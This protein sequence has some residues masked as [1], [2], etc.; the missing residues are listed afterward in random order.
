LHI[1]IKHTQVLKQCLLRQITGKILGWNS[2]KKERE[3]QGSKEIYQKDKRNIGGSKSSARE[4]T[5][6]NE[7][8]CR[9]KKRGS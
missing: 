5:K 9:Q 3:I 2:K 4:G 7:E 6:G 8:V 1:T